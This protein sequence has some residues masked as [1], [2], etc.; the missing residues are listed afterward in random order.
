MIS[1]INKTIG[2]ERQS[3]SRKL[4]LPAGQAEQVGEAEKHVSL[5]FDLSMGGEV[6][7]LR[8][9]SRSLRLEERRQISNVV[10]QAVGAELH[11]F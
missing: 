9:L 3:P 4:D 8:L 11:T 2:V 1:I 6:E 5:L 10:A 7:P